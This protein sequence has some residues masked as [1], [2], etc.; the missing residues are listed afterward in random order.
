MRSGRAP[1]R[2]AEGSAQAGR[3]ADLRESRA[4]ECVHPTTGKTVSNAGVGAND[5]RR[6]TLSVANFAMTHG[7]A[8]QL[9]SWEQLLETPHAQRCSTKPA[10]Q[11]D[12][13]ARTPQERRATT[14]T[15]LSMGSSIDSRR[16][17]WQLGCKLPRITGAASIG[18]MRLDVYPKGGECYD[19][20]APERWLVPT[21]RSLPDTSG[22][23]GRDALPDAN[24]LRP[25]PRPFTLPV[26]H[27][28]HGA[29][30]PPI[31]VRT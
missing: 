2:R 25:P 23:L 6:L 20:S 12:V 29:R 3:P 15:R 16:G 19:A 9:S 1:E 8:E 18:S 22:R 7:S 10:P 14:R 17:T 24:P 4:A 11:S 31:P 30:N 28:P 26:A 13:V 5:R 21:G 27:C